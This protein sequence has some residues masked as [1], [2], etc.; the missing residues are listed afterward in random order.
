MTEKASSSASD[1]FAEPGL[2]Q[3]IQTVV[4]STG[5]CF[6]NSEQPARTREDEIARSSF[7]LIAKIAAYRTM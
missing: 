2:V 6:T 1:L 5:R 7:P 3:L 4:N